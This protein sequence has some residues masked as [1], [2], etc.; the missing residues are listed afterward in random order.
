M[1][2]KLSKISK[3]PEKWKQIEIINKREKEEKNN[4]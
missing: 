1:K 3:K 2:G 4:K